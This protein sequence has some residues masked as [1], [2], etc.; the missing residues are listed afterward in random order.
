MFVS[1]TSRPRVLSTPTFRGT[2]QYIL[3]LPG[4]PDVQKL[5]E[6]IAGNQLAV[7]QDGSQAATL[8]SDTQGVDLI[9]H[10]GTDLPNIPF[11]QRD[12]QGREIATRILWA[13]DHSALVWGMSESDQRPGIWLLLPQL[14]TQVMG[15]DELSSIY[16]GPHG[17]IPSGH[18]YDNPGQVALVNRWGCW[19]VQ[20]SAR[21][22]VLEDGTLLVLEPFNELTYA[23]RVSTNGVVKNF[24]VAPLGKGDLPVQLLRWKGQFILAGKSEDHSWLREFGTGSRSDGSDLGMIQGELEAAWNAPNEQSIALLT[25]LRTRKGTI[26]RLFLN[27]TK[28]HEGSFTMRRSDLYWSLSGKSLAAVIMEGGDG[29]KRGRQLIVTPTAVKEVP[30]RRLVRDLLVGDRG[31]VLAI[32]LNDGVN[33]H[34]YVGGRPHEAVPH[35][36]NLHTD[37]TGGVAYNSVHGPYIMRWLDQT[38]VKR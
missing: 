33:D 25:R 20:P 8:V 4:A 9:A 37:P 10:T 29:E 22:T 18:S 6:L 14:A 16:D 27:G 2:A 21:V 7:N 13:G 31:Q 12:G 32:V 35:A 36:W 26:R 38:D 23:Y 1:T 11:L 15:L 19:V 3:R 5:T 28:V 34:P 30:G 17:G 24:T